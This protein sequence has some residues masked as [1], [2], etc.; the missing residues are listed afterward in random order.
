MKYYFHASDTAYFLRR[1]HFPPRGVRPHGYA[2]RVSPAP[3]CGFFVVTMQI[4]IYCILN[5]AN[6]KRYIGQSVNLESRWIQHLRNLRNGNHFNDHLQYAF[7]Q[8]GEKCFSY[9]V[10]ESV[11]ISL[12][13]ER[14]IHWIRLFNSC[15]Q[16]C[17]YN[18]WEGGFGKGVVPLMIRQ[19]IS[20]ALT[21]KKRSA[22][23]VMKSAIG[24]T[25]KKRSEEA[26]RRMSG[27]R[28]G[29]EERIRLSKSQMGR[30]VTQETRNKLS[31]INRQQIDA[32]RARTTGVPCLPETRKKISD[33][34]KGRKLS[35]EH[36]AH[37]AL[38]GI[39]RKLSETTK[40]KISAFH[41]GNKWNLG[42]KRSLAT[43]LLLSEKA[44]LRE[45]R[46]REKC[47]T[48]NNAQL[49]LGL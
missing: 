46:K 26:R 10:L 5:I 19:K 14:E 39:G 11:E 12:L 41:K 28:P 44:K 1:N 22:E 30:V 48:N 45:L 20:K 18:I 35:E 3:V 49:L 25:G 15:N 4:G 23:S 21:G 27:R 32:I 34:L 13:D 47:L 43:R 33:T 31:A 36:K 9:S 7:T 6:G 17:G 42:H 16:E 24:N 29:L 8:Y 40:S 2:L 38:G 37:I